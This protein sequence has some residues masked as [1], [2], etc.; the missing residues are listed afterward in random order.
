[1]NFKPKSFQLLVMAFVVLLTGISTE[2]VVAKQKAIAL[3]H[4]DIVY[5]GRWDQSDVNN[6]HSYWGGAYF[7]VQFY[8]KELEINLAAPVNIFVS[9]D[10][11]P[12]KLYVAAQGRIKLTP[13]SLSNG[14]HHIRVIAKFQNDEIQLTGLWLNEGG[15]LLKPAKRNLW[16]EFIGDSITSGDRTSKGNISAYP[17]LCGETL[18]VQHTQISYC[19]IPL[20]NN[21][22]HYS[23]K[24]APET[25][26]ELDYFKL[27]EPNHQPNPDWNFQR[28]PNVVV[29][30]LGTNDKH[31]KITDELFQLRYTQF[32][33]KI[34]AILPHTEIIILIPFNASY[35]QQIQDMVTQHFAQD[36]HLI[37]VDTSDWLAPQDF[38]DGTHPTDEG[39]KIVAN[40]L[41]PIIKSFL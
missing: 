21:G 9:L 14:I 5:V 35:K 36:Q 23:Y 7:E 16:V 22:T 4:K 3:N 30:N 17:W 24:G 41:D 27:K 19:G 8:G 31:L 13:D 28:Y 38:A 34:R 39:H 6:Y 25:G 18:K 1:M 33:Q 20:V 32:V 40:K 29:I 2:K 11:Q 37:L 12:E 15:K 10:D 26:M